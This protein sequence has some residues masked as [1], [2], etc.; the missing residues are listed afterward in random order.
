MEVWG[1]LEPELPGA[2]HTPCPSLHHQLY[3][4]HPRWHFLTA[5]PPVIK[6]LGVLYFRLCQHSYL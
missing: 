4:S 1:G 2:L 6:L 5:L 3:Q